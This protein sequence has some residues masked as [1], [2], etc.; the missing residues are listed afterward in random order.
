MWREDPNFP[1]FSYE[2]IDFIYEKRTGFGMGGVD[3][4]P[5]FFQKRID[6]FFKI[7]RQIIR[8]WKASIVIFFIAGNIVAKITFKYLEDFWGFLGIYV[9]HFFV[10]PD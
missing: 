10:Y 5:V 4:F 3:L 6:F 7:I 1:H 8:F 2:K 9:R